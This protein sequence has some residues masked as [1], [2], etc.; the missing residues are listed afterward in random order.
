M[1]LNDSKKTFLHS[2][3]VCISVRSEVNGMEYEILVPKGSS[4]GDLI[5]LEVPSK[6]TMGKFVAPDS[7]TD[8]MPSVVKHLEAGKTF[9]DF[10]IDFN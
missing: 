5:Y 3:L 7:T 1:K 6:R 8:S 2:A 10:Q 4:A 9:F